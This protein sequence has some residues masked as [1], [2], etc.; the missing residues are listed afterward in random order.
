MGWLYPPR[1]RSHP[2]NGKMIAFYRQQLGWTQER[3]AAAAGYT[4]R[5]V[6]E[7]E[8]G[9]T[10]HADTIEVLAELLAENGLPVT[11]EDLVS[12][13]RLIGL[14]LVSDFCRHE[15]QFVKH[16]QEFMAEEFEFYISHGPL[17]LPFTGRFLG[18][19]GMETHIREFFEWSTGR[20]GWSMPIR[21]PS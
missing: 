20:I 10:L 21:R 17:D 14:R 11:P 18:H 16:Y 9:G 12:D 8:S 1:W 3:F 6:T 5:L 15:R 2:V 4:S 13:P 7:A 19:D